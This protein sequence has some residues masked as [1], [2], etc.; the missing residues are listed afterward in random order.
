MLGSLLLLDLHVFWKEKSLSNRFGHLST[1]NS[2]STLE[3]RVSFI[4]RSVLKKKSAAPRLFQVVLMHTSLRNLTCG[5]LKSSVILTLCLFW[6]LNLWKLRWSRSF[7]TADVII[8][9]LSSLPF[10]PHDILSLRKSRRRSERR[11][12]WRSP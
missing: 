8:L 5:F 2:S 4:N 9:L 12:R 3:D 10:L 11:S 6:G 7:L 1:S